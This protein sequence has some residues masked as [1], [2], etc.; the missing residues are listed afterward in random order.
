MSVQ[1]CFTLNDAI[2][3]RLH[4]PSPSALI[5]LLFLGPELLTF[6]TDSVV[7]YPVVEKN[8]DSDCVRLGTH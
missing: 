4:K 8:A 7:Y 5:Q 3:D 6:M 2:V 1:M